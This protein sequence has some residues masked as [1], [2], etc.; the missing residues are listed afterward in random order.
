MPR[1]V[2]CEVGGLNVRVHPHDNDQYRELFRMLFDLRSIIPIRGDRSGLITSL[3]RIGDHDDYVDGV[4]TTFLEFDV[5]GPWFD[6][7]TMEEASDNELQK[8]VIP[9]HLRPNARQFHFRFYFEKHE[10]IFELYGQGDRLTHQSALA[11]FRGLF[12]EKSVANRFGDVKVTIIQSRGSIDT[13]FAIPRITDLEIYIEKPNSDLWGGDFEDQAEEHLDDKNARSMRVDYKSERGGGI[14][15]DEDLDAL[16][17]ASIRNG[18]TIA[19]GYGANGHEVVTTSKYPKVV[20]DKF[21][22][23]AWGGL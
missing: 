10:L 11:F 6:T 23:D 5:E 19:K 2:K 17:R 9:D 15:R 7:D 1:R 3:R 13:I 18:K 12:D 20:Q 14:T 21:D 8:V 16:I 4:L 22:Q